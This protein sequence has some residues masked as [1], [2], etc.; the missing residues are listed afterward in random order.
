MLRALIVL[1]T[2]LVLACDHDSAFDPRPAD[3]TRTEAATPEPDCAANDP[4]GSAFFGDLHVHTGLSSDAWAFGVRVRPDDAYRY[5]FGDAI[6]LPPYAADG[7]GRRVTIDRPLDFA[8]VTDHA[9]FLGEGSVCIDPGSDAYESG[10]CRAYREHTGRNPWLILRIMSP[11]PWRSRAACGAEG[12]GCAKAAASAWQEIVAAAER[13]N[14][15]TP[16]CRRTTFI[17]YEYSSHRLGSNL[18]RNVIFRNASVPGLPISYIEAP[19]EW[20]LWEGLRATCLDAEN[21]CD[22]IAIPHNPNLSNGRMFALDY[23][24]AE[25][26]AEQR[27]RAALRA[28]LEPI[29]EIMQHKGDSECRVEIAGVLSPADELCSFEKFEDVVLEVTPGGPAPDACGE[30]G[31]ADWTPH[32][33]PDCVAP[34]SYVRHA[35]VMGLGE[36]ERLGVNPYQFGIVASTDT[37]NGLAGGVRERDFPGHLGLGDDE[38]VE[39]VSRDR[40]I[41]GN[42]SNNPGGLMG[43]WAEENSRRALFAA[44]KRREVFGTSGPRIRVRFFGG[45]D[46]EGDLCESANPIEAALLDG[47][48]MGSDLPGRD[49]RDEDSGPPTFVTWAARDPGTQDQPGGLLQRIQII[50]GW[51]DDDGA[52]HERIYDVAGDPDNGADVDPLTCA[53][54]G[55][56]ADSLCSTWRDPDWDPARRAV[57]Y[58]RVVENPSCRYTAW[59]CLAIAPDERPADCDDP[60]QTKIV[61]ERAWSSPIWYA[62]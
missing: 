39:R 50:K 20:D 60:A 4:L 7:S 40:A 48:A 9:E 59:Q 30:G 13:W 62:P 33:G 2:G 11:F 24:G 16:A 35:L 61:Q 27:A 5:A 38:A 51:Q 3:S 10:F 37:H 8:A 28:R 31:F 18:H 25:D 32:L 22:V 17:A 26:L 1:L 19:R 41:P 54:R 34:G 46:Y 47:V 21:R 14:D 52:I 55:P 36:A 43:V 15:A 42:A 56:G 6:E 12:R 29:V 45:F 23:P 58:A 53:P 44:M 49:E 57:Y